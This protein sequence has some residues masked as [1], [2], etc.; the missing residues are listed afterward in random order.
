MRHLVIQK[1]RL[2]ALAPCRVPLL[3]VRSQV[4]LLSPVLNVDST[5]QVFLFIL[6]SW[7]L[8]GLFVV[9]SK[10]PMRALLIPS[11]SLLM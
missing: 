10:W 1:D 5:L 9:W 7:I 2:R 4:R 8:L 6:F 3:R 11:S